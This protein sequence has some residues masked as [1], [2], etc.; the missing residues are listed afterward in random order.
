MKFTKFIVLIGIILFPISSYAI[1]YDT[2]PAYPIYDSGWVLIWNPSTIVDWDNSI[3]YAH[4]YWDW[5]YDLFSFFCINRKNSN[6]WVYYEWK[7]S[8]TPYY[9]YETEPYHNWISYYA[10]GGNVD[11]YIFDKDW[12]SI[13]STVWYISW[14]KDSLYWTHKDD[15][16]MCSVEHFIYV[17]P[18]SSKSWLWIRWSDRYVYYGNTTQH[19]SMYY[20]GTNSSNRDDYYWVRLNDTW[21][22]SPKYQ[23][24]SWR[25]SFSNPDWSNDQDEKIWKAVKEYLSYTGSTWLYISSP[26]PF[27]YWT[28][29][30]IDGSSTWWT[31]S[32]WIDYY[33]DCTSFIDVWCYIKWSYNSIKW[34]FTGLVPSIAWQWSMESCAW[35]GVITQNGVLAPLSNLIAI[36]NPFPPPGGTTVCTLLWTQ[37]IH[38]HLLVPEH[39]FFEVYAHGKVPS[40]LE[41]NMYVM[42]WQ[43]IID[44]LVIVIFVY[45]SFSS[46]H[47]KND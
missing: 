45:L 38:Y 13:Y 23:W 39:N 30:Y 37:I 3:F 36:L 5:N 34:F 29:N 41:T 33:S 19:D 8:S 42:P 31:N 11:Q 21:Y 2:S 7:D 20:T 10:S 17:A 9:G 15:M 26:L 46:L 40:E 1:N 18:G 28:T 4:P 16:V 43:T 25:I 47:K 6:W 24:F 14:D 44:V 12:N 27:M 35:S 32:W 22:I